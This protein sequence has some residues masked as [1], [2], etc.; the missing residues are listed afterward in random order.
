[1]DLIHT[2]YSQPLFLTLFS[3]DGPTTIKHHRDHP[4]ET[5]TEGTWLKDATVKERT[6]G[7]RWCTTWLGNSQT[8]KSFYSLHDSVQEKLRVS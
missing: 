7:A 2:N 5:Y 3:A 1:M 8:E 6:P 4:V